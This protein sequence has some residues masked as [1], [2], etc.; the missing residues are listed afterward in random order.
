MY[1]L[2]IPNQQDS[3]DDS[4]LYW[5]AILGKYSIITMLLLLACNTSVLQ[6]SRAKQNW[7]LDGP[8]DKQLSNFAYPGKVIVKFFSHLVGRQL[9]WVLAHHTS[10][11]EKLA[12]KQ[13]NLLV[14]DEWSTLV[15]YA[16]FSCDAMTWV[17]LL[18]VDRLTH[19]VTSLLWVQ[20]TRLQVSQ[21]L[22]TALLSI[23]YCTFLV[24]IY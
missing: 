2:L 1:W 18:V 20:R 24:S 6:L 16:C 7:I 5:R 4:T 14:L 10:D 9:V 21:N 22:M 23:N 8:S 19:K 12:A 17:K 11:N 13:E 3:F 15:E